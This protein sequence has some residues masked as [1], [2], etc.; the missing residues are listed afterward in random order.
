MPRTIFVAHPSVML[1]D[2]LSHGDGLAAFNFISRLAAR[3]HRLH[4]MAENVELN[5]PLAGDVTLHRI[6]RRRRGRGDD[7][8][9][10]A[11]QIRAALGHVQKRESVDLVHQLNPVDV[12]LTC[13]LPRSAPPV[14]LGPYVPN[15]PRLGQESAEVVRAA[16]HRLQQRRAG[17]LLLSSP[18]ARAK[19][20]STRPSLH[21]LGYGVDADFFHPGDRTA[22]RSSRPP[23]LLFLANLQVRKGILDLVHSFDLMAGDLPECRLVIAGGGPDE[24]QVRRAVRAS[25]H[26]DRVEL[27]GRL[28]RRQAAETMRE[29][30][31]YCLPS[32]GEPFGI[33]ALEAMSAGMPVVATDSGGLAHLVRPE[34]GRR[35]P[36]GDPDALA[37]ALTELVSSPSLRRE[38][39]AFNRKLVTQRYSW[40]A[41]VD[42]LEQIYD[43]VAE[44][45]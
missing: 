4:V 31:V 41:V 18:A 6:S 7:Q 21:E 15:W 12:G 14:V 2:H 42:R 43:E 1:T 26:R 24:E 8:V 25:P 11:W 29:A 3:G 32:H 44:P 33:S 37:A 22:D 30:D 34:G 10:A 35:V 13:L 45:R 39:G 17:A 16:V 27:R 38:M 5:E 36:P 23:L 28:G 9:R 20:R 40:D 19:V